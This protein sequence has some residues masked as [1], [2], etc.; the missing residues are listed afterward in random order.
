V[1]IAIRVRH[2]SIR[3]EEA[4]VK[5]IRRYIYFHGKQ[6]PK[7]L[8]E[9]HVNQFLSHLAV[10][11]RVAAKTFT[12][13]PQSIKS[14]LENHLVETRTIFQFDRKE[15]IDSVYLPFA[16]AR[17]YPRQRELGLAIRGPLVNAFQRSPLRR[18]QAAHL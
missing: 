16:L 13:L 12:M 9:S 7:D 11:R 2:Y 5:W 8:R 17:K 4:C 14:A 3:T 6:H 15:K 1:R 18:P 10:K